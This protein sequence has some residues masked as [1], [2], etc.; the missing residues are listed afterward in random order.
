MKVP[1]AFIERRAIGK[2]C[3]KLGKPEEEGADAGSV[4]VLGD[5][6]T[7]RWLLGGRV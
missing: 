4:G 6:G 5:R 1:I 7:I 2:R 3:G